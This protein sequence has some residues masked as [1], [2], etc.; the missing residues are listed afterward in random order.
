[1]G[2][3]SGRMPVVWIRYDAADG[4]QLNRRFENAYLAR[5]FYVEQF[6][7]GRN[8]QVISEDKQLGQQT[9]Q[10]ATELFER[11]E[12]VRTAVVEG[13]AYLDTAFGRMK[14]TSYNH[15]TG[16]ASVEARRS[17]MVSLND[18]KIVERPA[19]SAPA[20]E[21]HNDPPPHKPATFDNAARS[22]Q[23]EL[24]VGLGDLPGQTYFIPES[25]VSPSN[26]KGER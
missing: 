12:A 17:F 18:I 3:I 14:V 5:S 24:F 16:W 23:Q 13:R 7:A 19:A 22:R 2:A 11:L 6:K 1:M 20:F 9:R 15:A 8:P 21:L 25:N 10:L 26:P 4:R